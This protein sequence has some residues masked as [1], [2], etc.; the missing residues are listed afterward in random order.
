MSDPLFKSG[1]TLRDEGMGLAE[2]R[3]ERLGV[4]DALDEAIF[5]AAK[6]NP[7]VTGE[8]LRD[9]IPPSLDYPSAAIGPTFKRAAK[10]GWIVATGEFR[11][12]TLAANHA[13]HYRVWKSAI[14]TGAK[15]V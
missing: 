8:T 10:A 12:S 14:F 9:F 5:Q 13:H 2:D 6:A 11:Q 15:A 1:E 3:A 7:E 4:N